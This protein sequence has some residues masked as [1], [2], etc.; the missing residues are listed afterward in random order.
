MF[1]RV[2]N[3]LD[4]AMNTFLSGHIDSAREL[5]AR[6]TELRNLERSGT[7]RHLERL[8]DGLHKSLVTSGIHLD[9]LRDFKRINSHLTSV[10]YPVLERAGE[11]RQ[12]RLTKKAER[13]IK[14][15]PEASSR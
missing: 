10:A 7:E 9:V 14:Y 12:S 13:L 5:I 2:L 15:Q 1:E 4:L 3:T 11:L 6:K 8:S